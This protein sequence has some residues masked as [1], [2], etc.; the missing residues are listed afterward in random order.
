MRGAAALRPPPVPRG[1]PPAAVRDAPCTGP[2]APCPRIRGA[3]PGAGG[4]SPRLS[5]AVGPGPRLPGRAG[6]REQGTGADCAAGVTR[7][8]DEAARGRRRPARR[9][10]NPARGRARHGRVSAGVREASWTA[11]N[12]SGQCGGPS[13]DRGRLPA[14]TARS[15][16]QRDNRQVLGHGA[17]GPAADVLADGPARGPRR[18]AGAG[19]RD[20]DD[21]VQAQAG[22]EGGQ[23]GD[24]PAGDKRR[25]C[26]G[27]CVGIHLG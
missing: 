22:A 19:H 12:P 7:M 18:P 26:P 5:V 20:R 1:P 11:Q 2:V 21:P 10:R 8:T 25:R 27:S 23:P 13:G 3:R 4:H 14:L 15:G 24:A 17:A 6:R 9:S 16:H